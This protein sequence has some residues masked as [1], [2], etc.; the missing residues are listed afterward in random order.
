[1]LIDYPRRQVDGTTDDYAAYLYGSTVLQDSS[2]VESFL[3]HD[4][5]DLFCLPCPSPVVTPICPRAGFI[6]GKAM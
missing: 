2:L 4:D 1:M 3:D 6:R 5:D